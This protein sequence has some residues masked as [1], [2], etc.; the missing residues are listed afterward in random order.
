[1]LIQPRFAGPEDLLSDASF[2]RSLRQW[3]SK[4]R[5]TNMH[6]ER[7]LGRLKLTLRGHG[8]GHG[9]TPAADRLVST[10]M[11]GRVLSARLGAGG[12]DPRFVSR[13]QLLLQEAPIR[14]SAKSTEK[15]RPP[16]GFVPFLAEQRATV[17]QRLGL[18]SLTKAQNDEVLSGTC[19]AF[20]LWRLGGPSGRVQ[21]FCV[22]NPTGVSSLLAFC[23]CCKEARCGGQGCLRMSR[24]IGLARRSLAGWRTNRA[25]MKSSGTRLERPPT[26]THNW[27][28]HWFRQ[29]V[30]P[31]SHI[32]V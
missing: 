13:E 32:F 28:G 4:T 7:L 19:K 25:R 30:H 10:G 15:S 16:S 11:L 1:M 23:R 21:L 2:L 8:V 3:V 14:C 9:S 24:R 26:A 17:R 12:L 31:A 29:D 6:I 27:L 22:A 5:L 18:S 20:F